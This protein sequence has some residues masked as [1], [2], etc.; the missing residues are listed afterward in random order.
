MSFR[1]ALAIA[2][3]EWLLNRRDVRSLIVIALLPQVLLILYCLGLNFEPTHLPIAVQDLDRSSFS[4]R[5]IHRLAASRYFKIAAFVHTAAD[6][7]RLLRS[8]AARAVLIIPPARAV[9]GCGRSLGLVLD[10]ADAATAGTALGYMQAFLARLSAEQARQWARRR[11]VSSAPAFDVR[12]RVLYNPSFASPPFI[13]P[14]LIGVV[15]ALMA[16][17]LTTTCIVREREVGTLEALLATPTAPAE[18]MLGKLLPYAAFS[19]IDIALCVI[20]GG[21]VFGV[22]PRGSLLQFAIISAIFILGCLSTGLLI[23]ARATSQRTAI[24]GGVM[25]LMLPT[26][27]LSGFVFPLQHMPWPLRAIATLLPATHYIALSRAIYLRGASVL[28]FWPDLAML[29][30][31]T[32]ALFLAAVRAFRPRL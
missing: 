24:V 23:S 17:L 21:I 25:T 26:V 19:M 28:Q 12:T 7:S 13:I 22:W 18:L 30:V 3:A 10:G 32:A 5:V 8:G 4:R 6:M 27:V 2:R 11:G 20:A 16:A 29:V 14:G 15:M 9:K 31:L 1:R